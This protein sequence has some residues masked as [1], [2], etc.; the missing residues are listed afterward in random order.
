MN[1]KIKYPL[2]NHVFNRFYI[3]LAALIVIPIIC[4]YSIFQKTKPKD[5]ERFSIFADIEFKND[6]AFKDYLFTELKEDL[7]IDIYESNRDDTLFN[8]YFSSYGLNSDICILSKKTLDKF[9]S[10]NF[11]DLT[12]TDFDNPDNYYFKEA[13]IGV[14]YHQKDSTTGN[15]YINF[16]IAEDDYYITI[17]K[18]SVHLKGITTTGLTDQVYRVINLLTK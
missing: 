1:M 13:S 11:V 15:E 7:V 17:N 10:I 2:K 5:Y 14:L 8:T 9:E 3:Y 12:G 16:P 18:N 4:T 6:G